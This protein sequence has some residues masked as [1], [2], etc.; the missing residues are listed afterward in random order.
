[1]GNYKE[2]WIYP[3]GED[4][5]TFNVNSNEIVHVIEYS[6][7]EQ[8]QQENAKLKEQLEIATKALVFYKQ[9]FDGMPTE[10]QV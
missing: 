7:Y 6:A 5:F 9:D 3:T 2:F 1:M 4:V 10:E 8:L